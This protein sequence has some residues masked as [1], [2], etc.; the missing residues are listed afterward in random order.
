MSISFYDIEMKVTN[1][2]M[3]LGAVT[4]PGDSTIICQGDL[5][6]AYFVLGTGYVSCS[7]GTNTS[8]CVTYPNILTCTSN[9]LYVTEIKRAAASGVYSGTIPTL[10][11]QLTHLTKIVYS[12]NQLSGTIP[13]EIG[14][15]NLAEEI[16]FSNNQLSGNIP[17][18]FGKIFYKKNIYLNDNQLTGSIPTEIGRYPGFERLDLSANML[19]GPL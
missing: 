8:L 18:E 9:N 10:L 14:L 1:K 7:T 4:Y 5:S 2:D 17:T 6:F 13:T 19:S 3:K 12:N 11:G 15:L 16:D